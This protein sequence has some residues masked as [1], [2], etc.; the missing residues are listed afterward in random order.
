MEDD[1]KLAFGLGGKMG[2][3]VTN[4]KNDLL[5]LASIIETTLLPK[6]DKMASRLE[7]VSKDF[8]GLLIADK[9][10]R[11]TGTSGGSNRVAPPPP[12]E[13]GNNGAPPTNN[14][15]PKTPQDNSAGKPTNNKIAAGAQAVLGGMYGSNLLSMAMPNVQ[16]SIMQDYLTNRVAFNGAGGITGSLQSQTGQ[17]NALQRSMANQGTATS[18]MDAINAIIA[19]QNAGLGGAKNFKQLAS[20]AAAISNLEPGMGLAGAA[21]AQGAAQAPTT[22]N[23]L[24]SIGINMR[25]ANGNMLT[26]GQMIDQIWNFLNKNN[27]GKNMDK[28]SITMSLAPGYGLYNMLSSMFN[29]DPMMI[30][31]VGD[32]L[33]LKAQTGGAAIDSLTRNQMKTLGGTT[34]AVN[35]IANKTAAQT[36]LLTNTAATTSA[37]YA[38]SAE[39]AA[40]LNRFADMVPQLTSALGGLNGLMSGVK[41]IGG[42]ALTSVAGAYAANKVAKKVESTGLLKGIGNL[43]SKGFNFLKGNMVRA[44]EDIAKGDVP[45][46]AAAVMEDVAAGGIAGFAGGTSRVPGTGDGDIVPAMLTPGEAVI[47]KD[48]AEKYRP[49]LSAMNAGTLQMHAAGTSN[50]AKAE[51]YLSKM[52]S[53]KVS[54]GDFAQAMLVGLGAP[55]DAQNVANLKLW[56]SAEGGNWLNTAHFNP[57]NTS[58]GLNGSTNFNTGM[59]G[60]GVQA[61]KSWKDGLDATLGTLTGQNAGARGYANLVKMLQGGK[62]SQSEWITA[63]QQSSWDNGHYSNLSHGGNSNYN[64]NS[65]YSGHGSGGATSTNPAVPTQAQIAA[66]AAALNKDAT[67]NHNYGGVSITINAQNHSSDALLSQL[68]QLFAGSGIVAQ[69]SG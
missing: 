27:G 35:A 52:N 63:L 25:D 62:A 60:G 49:I 68:Q 5:S 32:G 65:P 15:S 38:A 58:Y 64:P 45:D 7:S 61:Y 44:G 2:T 6:I 3:A 29:G 28:E 39:L 31:L 57:L 10:G 37:G 17:V 36:E 16:T 43:F 24:R 66:H 33:K 11:V 53:N 21:Q 41:G 50:V 46:F 4:I 20:G 34:G 14:Q 55:T 51:S 40:A 47:N 22:V 30:K 26:T 18:S 67:N 9:Y 42:G 54:A 48:A 8:S 23:M 59:A 69:I 12:T 1:V 56:M 19:L 13:T